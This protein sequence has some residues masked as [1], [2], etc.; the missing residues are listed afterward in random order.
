MDGSQANG[1]PPN[2][3]L[4]DRSRPKGSQKKGRSVII[5]NVH[6]YYAPVVQTEGSETHISMTSGSDSIT[7]T[8]S[9]SLGCNDIFLDKIMWF[10][11]SD[12]SHNRKICN[13]LLFTNNRHVD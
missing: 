13:I 3:V 12:I 6:K 7:M 5:Q 8:V 11:Y 2:E 10:L 4:S 9:I 1:N